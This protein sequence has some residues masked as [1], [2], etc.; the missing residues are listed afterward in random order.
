MSP[1]VVTALAVVVVAC[2]VLLVNRDAMRRRM[3]RRRQHRT[4]S[5][6]FL[7]FPTTG[8]RI[9]PAWHGSAGAAGA[10]QPVSEIERPVRPQPGIAD[11]PAGRHPVEPGIADLPGFETGLRGMWEESEGR[12]DESRPR[13]RSDD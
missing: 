10:A 5:L 8:K 4:S 6:P 13:L 11:L 1:V 9:A 3:R 12:P 2:A 7:F